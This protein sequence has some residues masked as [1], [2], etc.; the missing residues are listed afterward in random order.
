M[1]DNKRTDADIDMLMNRIVD[2]ATQR[3]FESFDDLHK[4]NIHDDE[5]IHSLRRLGWRDLAEG[6]IEWSGALDPD[7]VDNLSTLSETVPDPGDAHSYEDLGKLL[8]RNALNAYLRSPEITIFG[9]RENTL[10]ILRRQLPIGTKVAYW[11]GPLDGEFTEA[12]TSSE[13][14]VSAGVPV[15]SLASGVQAAALA[16]LQV[17][18]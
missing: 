2:H 13:V 16:S 4:R 14:W 18:G 11:R 17:I 10:Q 7:T 3:L 15:V 5:V 8:N 9:A 12:V 6:Y 1:T